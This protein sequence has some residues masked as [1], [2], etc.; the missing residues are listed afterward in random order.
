MSTIKITNDI[1]N[2]NEF[3]NTE[4]CIEILG[5]GERNLASICKENLI[6]KYSLRRE[7]ATYIYYKKDE[8][9]GVL[10]KQ[11]E[12]NDS[13]IAIDEAIKMITPKAM[14]EADRVIVPP[15]A[16]VGKYR[17]SSRAIRKSDIEK[18]ITERNYRDK[19]VSLT[20]SEISDN[21]YSYEETKNILGLTKK[22]FESLMRDENFIKGSFNRRTYYLKREIDRIK[23]MQEEGE[24]LYL[25]FTSAV[26]KY[27]RTIVN[28]VTPIPVPSYLR[29]SKFN[30][31]SSLYSI[32]EL[33]K[34]KSE[35]ELELSMHEILS[36]NVDVEFNKRLDTYCELNNIDI[37]KFHKG[38][39]YTLDK[40]MD[41]ALTKLVDSEASDT[42]IKRRILT[43]IYQ[44]HEL[45]NMLNIDGDF[46][47]VYTLT[48]SYLDECLGNMKKTYREDLIRF[49]ESVYDELKTEMKKNK[50]HNKKIFDISNIKKKYLDKSDEEKKL[51]QA[52]IYSISDFLSIFEY[53]IEI[54]KHTKNAVNEIKNN[55]T[56]TYASVWLYSSIH[57]N[58]G[59]R[60]GDII[61][62]QEVYIDDLLDIFKISSVDYFLNNKLTLGQAQIIISRIIDREIKISKTKMSG[63]FFCCDEVA[64]SVATAIVLLT[65]YNKNLQLKI[66]ED[67]LKFNT[68]ENSPTS[69][70]INNFFRDIKIYDFKFKSRKMNST[71]LTLIYSITYEST[72]DGD[73]A[74]KYVRKSRF[75][76]DDSESPLHYIKINKED[77][78]HLSKILFD[79]GEFGYIYDQLVKS[80]YADGPNISNKNVTTDKIKELKGF[81]GSM[82]NI[83]QLCGFMNGYLTKKKAVLKELDCIS[84]EKKIELLTDI[85][86]FNLPSNEEGIHCIIGANNCLNYKS[87]CKYCPYSII[88]LYALHDICDSFIK[89]LALYKKETLPGEKIKLSVKLNHLA[90]HIVDALDR[91][92]KDLV[93]YYFKM[94]FKEF[95]DEYEALELPEDI[96]Y[97]TSFI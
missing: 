59:W 70:Q 7:K 40:W 64:P 45:Y 52:D 65:L 1:Y 18:I 77:I 2:E 24:K 86:M 87:G 13:H 8:I 62:F 69:S 11:Q 50:I 61:K 32:E 5:I 57:L 55:N 23:T 75:H 43:R 82:F 31:K 22:G 39:S 84:L 68:K 94:S 67:F 83:E 63:Y 56:A 76:V 21:Y 92:G 80:V 97:E 33:D 15:Y 71:L 36:D 60:H 37:D 17:G 14:R 74:L 16:R 88:T 47:E 20:E 85:Y 25:D 30:S 54:D 78:L 26:E 12:F 79:R 29:T 27:T 41:F 38:S 9:D 3:I 28:R 90:Q 10:K 73:K 96:Y 72:G 51:L 4:K 58:N 35:Y 81:L 66:C 89:N 34:K 53:C 49:L 19:R 93:S 95:V 44:T 42:T 46:V 48:T 91:F 6:N